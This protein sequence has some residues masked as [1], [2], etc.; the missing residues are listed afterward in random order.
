MLRKDLTNRAHIVQPTKKKRTS[1]IINTPMRQQPE[2]E[3][4]NLDKDNIKQYTPIQMPQSD[5]ESSPSIVVSVAST[6]FMNDNELY[7][8]HE[9]ALLD[10]Q[11]PERTSEFLKRTKQCSKLCNF[12]NKNNADKISD[13]TKA[14]EDMILTLKKTNIIELFGNEEYQY[15]FRMVLRHLNR[16]A[17]NNKM[18]ALSFTDLDMPFQFKEEEWEHINLIYDI[19]CEIFTSRKFNY[20]LCKSS[21]LQKVSYYVITMFASPD[22]REREKLCRVFNIQYVTLITQR[23]QM[24][25]YAGDFFTYVSQGISKPIGVAEL[26]S[27]YEPIVNGF[28]VPLLQEHVITFNTVFLPLHKCPYLAMFHLQLVNIITAYAEKQKSLI[29]NALRYILNIWPISPSAKEVYLMTE[30]SHLIEIT[31]GEIP[32]DIIMAITKRVA[33]SSIST[34]F[35]LSE[36]TMMM[37]QSDVFARTIAMSAPETFRIILPALYKTYKDHWCE[38]IRKLAAY[39]IIA[40]KQSNPSAFEMVG[41]EIRTFDADRIKSEKQRINKWREIFLSAALPEKVTN[42]LVKDLQIVA[43][44]IKA[45]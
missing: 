22:E 29:G 1:F 18:V 19:L 13:K 5:M 2:L 30:V 17:P 28:K 4:L 33:R 9:P 15:V 36:R 44:D 27:S 32:A 21:Q 39:A 41:T 16:C 23:Q 40:V 35:N 3:V 24:R 31:A 26:L 6:N 43:F 38:D 42:Q 12:S 25:K 45:I 37:W 20:R 34:S 10:L 11:E 7:F 14:L 8:E